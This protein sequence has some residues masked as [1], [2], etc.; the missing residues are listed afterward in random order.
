MNDVV[1]SPT[2][3]SARW[4]VAAGALIVA[5]WLGAVAW[6]AA[7]RYEVCIAI[8]PAPAGCVTAD[9]VPTAAVATAVMVAAFAVLVWLARRPGQRSWITWSAVALIACLAVATYRTVLYA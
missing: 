9:R 6:L 1:R 3:G 7:P 5:V 8:Y 2:R 4:P